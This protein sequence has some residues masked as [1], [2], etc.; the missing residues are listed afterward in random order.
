MSG[1][2]EQRMGWAMHVLLTRPYP[3]SREFAADLRSRGLEVSIA[4]ALNV[5]PASWD[6]Q[7][8]Q[9]ARAILLTSANA[10]RRLLMAPVSPRSL[11]VFAVGPESAGPLEEAG[12]RSV[13]VADGTAEGLMRLVQREWKPRDGRIAYLS[14]RHVTQDLARRLRDGGYDATRQ[15]VYQTIPTSGLPADVT[16]AMRAGT[17]H[18]ALF[19]SPRSAK[20]FCCHCN[21]LGLANACRSITAVALSAR[22]AS[23]LMSVPWKSVKVAAEPSRAGI[24]ATSLKLGSSVRCMS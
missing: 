14:G 6:K 17:L 4:P 18:A 12:F 9:E 16:A 8:L 13:R 19:M 11:P 7:A 1:R 23:P 20:V 10:A 3:Q 22:V 21:D 5:Y 2:F 15:I 24:V